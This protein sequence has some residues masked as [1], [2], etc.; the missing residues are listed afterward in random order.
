LLFVLLTALLTAAFSPSFV[1]APAAKLATDERHFGDIGVPGFGPTSS[2]S[3]IRN[4][5]IFESHQNVRHRVLIAAAVAIEPR[6]NAPC[7][8]SMTCASSVMAKFQRAG[9]GPD[10]EFLDPAGACNAGSSEFGRRP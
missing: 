1:F 8:A 10:T 9:A 7:A 4:A 5:R 3:L 6:L 2:R